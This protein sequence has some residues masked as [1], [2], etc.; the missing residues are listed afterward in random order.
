VR[1][2]RARL[3][4]NGGRML[5][6]GGFLP[7]SNPHLTPAVINCRDY[8]HPY[9]N[10]LHHFRPALFSVQKVLYTHAI[11]I[12]TTSLIITTGSRHCIKTKEIGLG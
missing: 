11:Q 10:V 2:G 12:L 6:Q 5:G 8:V 4:V 3:K 1:T 7:G 9:N